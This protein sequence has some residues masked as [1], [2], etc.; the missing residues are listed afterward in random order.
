MQFSS[1]VCINIQL[2]QNSR[3]YVLRNKEKIVMS[4]YCL[5]FI[6]AHEKYFCFSLFDFELNL[7]HYLHDIVFT[8]ECKILVLVDC[9][10][11]A[12]WRDGV[13]FRNVLLPVLESRNLK[14]GCPGLVS[15]ESAREGST[16]GLC[17]L[18][19]T[20]LFHLVSSAK[21]LTLNKISFP[22]AE[23]ELKSQ[24][25]RERHKSIHKLVSQHL[26]Y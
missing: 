5:P 9:C 21:T 17:Y 19:W 11:Q 8:Y 23:S 10:S 3:N 15:P 24:E 13:N 25:F 1:R 20:W 4:F 18:A 16:L 26:L 2:G 12:A 22:Q 6:V 7:K 14:S